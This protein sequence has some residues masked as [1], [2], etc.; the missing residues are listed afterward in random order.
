[1]I[2]CSVGEVGTQLPAKLRRVGSIP[3]RCLIPL[4]EIILCYISAGGKENN[5]NPWLD[6]FASIAAGL[7]PNKHRARNANKQAVSHDV[8]RGSSRFL[9]SRHRRSP[10]VVGDT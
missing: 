4:T 10:V 2:T 3:T 7:F 8:W 1:M 5:G 6:L 9:Y